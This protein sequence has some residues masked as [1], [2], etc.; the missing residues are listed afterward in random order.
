MDA[1]A[2]AERQE[3]CRAKAEHLARWSLGRARGSHHNVFDH[4]LYCRLG[5]PEGEY[6]NKD[7]SNCS[8]DFR[9]PGPLGSPRILGGNPVLEVTAGFTKKTAPDTKSNARSLVPCVFWAGR[10][11]IP[12]YR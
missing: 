5:K 10:E 8:V 3:D 7:G 12:I 2:E 4:R 1:R 11:T 6:E 9:T